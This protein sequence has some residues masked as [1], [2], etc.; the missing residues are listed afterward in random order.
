MSGFRVTSN[1]TCVS[2]LWTVEGC[3][4]GLSCAWINNV[5]VII[6]SGL[7]SFDGGFVL[8]FTFMR[9]VQPSEV[10]VNTQ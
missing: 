7:I 10:G 4:G 3:M 2:I 9:G 5:V 8:F 1:V 6:V